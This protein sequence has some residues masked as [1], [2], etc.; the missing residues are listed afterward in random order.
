MLRVSIMFHAETMY[1]FISDC[2]Q[3]QQF[4]WHFCNAAW[5]SSKLLTAQTSH[6][7]RQLPAGQWSRSNVHHDQ[8]YGV[9]QWLECRSSTGEL[10][11]IYAWSMADMWQ[12]CG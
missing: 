4:L 7:R 3:W 8:H 10:S 9:A 12:L 6:P 2:C 5:L 1:S 11:L